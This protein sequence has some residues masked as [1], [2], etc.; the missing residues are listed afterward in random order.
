MKLKHIFNRNMVA[1]VHDTLVAAA[2]FYLALY[3]RLGD[4]LLRHGFP[5]LMES[6]VLFTAIAVTV[7][8]LMRL[9]R[10]LW[11]YAS[12]KD[13]MTITKSVS[14]AVALFYLVIFLLHRL[15]TVPR[16][17][18]VI[19]WMVLLA[20][21][22]GPRF[23][24]RLVKDWLIGRRFSLQDDSRIPVLLV[25]ANENA[26]HFLRDM[27][28][29]RHALYRVVGIIEEDHRM[30]GQVMHGV[31]IYGDLDTIPYVV[32]KL[33]RR[34]DQP[35]RLILTD[36]RIQGASVRR[37]L[38]LAE[39]LGM[40]LA[41]LPQLS[42]L[43]SGI[44][45][46][47]QEIRPIAVEDLLG[48]AQNTRDKTL[49]REL[50][51]GK[52]VMVTG[53]GGSI[54]SE[55]VR[56]LADCQP[57]KIILLELSEFGLYKIDL[58]LS[59]NYPDLPREAVLADV[60][61]V[62]H[63]D[64]IFEQLQ[65]EIV[66]HAAAIKHVPIAEFNPEEAILTNVFGTR[67][68]AEACA[69]Y[70]VQAMVLISTDKAVNPANV[71]GATKRLAESFCQSL[72]ADEKARGR[73][74]FVTVRFGNVLGS[75][76]SVVPLFEKQLKRGGPITVTHPDMVRY[77]M[78][79]REA[80]ELVLEAATMGMRVED[81]RHGLI[82]VLDMGQPVKIEELAVQMI[83]LAGL[84][85]HEDIRI[86]YTGLRPGEKLYE[87]LFHYSETSSK[88]DHEGIMIATSRKA[89]LSTLKPAFAKLHKACQER[90]VKAAYKVLQKLV[91]EFHGGE[92]SE[93]GKKRAANG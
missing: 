64:H 28:G 82:F 27:D 93:E 31:R 11:R 8:V 50:V 40:T 52:R 87:E 67:N 60:R 85:P 47:K 92:L 44:A 18:P 78:T 73:T 45:D 13:L 77:F 34:G 74:R 2:S 6:T 62:N 72:G 68:I 5:Y 48:R 75:T 39:E 25:G 3:L 36:D 84:R 43:K 65:P 90:Q 4:L 20:L 80:V 89:S 37:L 54:G 35:Q 56:Q 91:P 32:K 59:E 57:A 30:G 53:A 83:R 55:L 69:K 23:F 51:E 24:Y 16:S 15:D 79:I 46:Q 86:T 7:F 61:D 9:Y 63:I 33:Q 17:V 81:H 26:G 76:G 70:L 21:L 66:F 42:D 58:E 38:D 88:T 1:V 29:N 12:I 71:M 41:R 22:G 19:H 10:G 49:V 14:L